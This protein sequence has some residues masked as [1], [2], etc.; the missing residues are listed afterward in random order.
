[1]NSFRN[2]VFAIVMQIELNVIVV[3]DIDSIVTDPTF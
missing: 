2:T 3:V 1:M